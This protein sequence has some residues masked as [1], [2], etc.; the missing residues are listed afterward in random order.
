MITKSTD[1]KLAPGKGEPKHRSLS[2]REIFKLA[3][4][5]L[6]GGLISGR[7]HFRSPISRTQ[8]TGYGSGSY[9]GA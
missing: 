8:R 9:G 2:R 5:A 1:Q 4:A 3:M 6:A 7:E